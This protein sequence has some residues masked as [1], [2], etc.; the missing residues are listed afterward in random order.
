M[1]FVAK[2]A[3]IIFLSSI[4]SKV[5]GFYREVL[6]G[7]IYGASA[8]TDAFFISLT[9]PW[10]LFGVISSGVLSSYLPMY[11]NIY[12]KNPKE[13][14]E[15]TSFLINI[16]SFIIV[17]IFYLLI[18]FFS[19]DLVGLFGNNFT[20][21]E[22]NLTVTFLRI[23]AFVL[24][25]TG[26]LSV[27]TGKLQYHNFFLIVPLSGVLLNTVIIICIFLSTKVSVYYLP[28]SIVLGNCIQFFIIAFYMKRKKLMKY[29][30]T[31]KVNHSNLTRF[32][33]L[34]V[35]IMIS[36]SSLQLIYFVD[37]II[38]SKTVLGGVSLVNYTQKINEVFV[39]LFII[40]ILSII[41]PKLS[42]I[43]NKNMEFNLVLKNS[44]EIMIFITIPLVFFITN[45]SKNIISIIYGSNSF[46][47]NEITVMSNLLILYSL[48]LIFIAVKELLMRALFS[49]RISNVT[50]YLSFI[51]LILNTALSYKLSMAYGL[52]GI[53]SAAVLSNFI[54]I[55]ILFSYLNFKLKTNLFNK[56]IITNSIFLIVSSFLS[57]LFANLLNELINLNSSHIFTLIFNCISFLIFLCLFLLLFK[58]ID[59]YKSITKE[60]NNNDH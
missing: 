13:A 1:V 32:I 20:E 35:P 38:A 25:F 4:L 3:I 26:V 41:F 7:Q 54:T 39:Q 53:P 18:Y 8:I 57:I 10:T 14:N 15:F 60:L 43:S 21:S 47:L 42:K 9:I 16:I 45:N 51:M 28:L 17:P 59:Y 5:I 11:S 23:T 6:I 34:I 29:E 24:F 31:F 30:F 36:A 22:I 49:K 37:Q 58:K 2:I 48:S 46:S 44:L 19:Y 12:S 50:M 56:K 55:L 33:K 52:I 27:W 40:T